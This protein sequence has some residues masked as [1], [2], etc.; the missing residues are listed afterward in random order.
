MRPIVSDQNSLRYPLNE[1][2]GAEAHVLAAES[3]GLKSAGL[4]TEIM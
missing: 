4:L 1:L 2:L 3:E